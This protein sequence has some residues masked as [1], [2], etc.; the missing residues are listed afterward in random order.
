MAK[1]RRRQKNTKKRLNKRVVIALAVLG[2]VAAVAV[3]LS[4]QRVRDWLFPPDPAGLASE[5]GNFVKKAQ[6]FVAEADKLAAEADKLVAEAR[7]FTAQ[8]D[9]LTAQANKLTGEA[10][11]KYE[12]AHKAYR[13][14]DTKYQ[15]AIYH[16][17]DAPKKKAEYCYLRGKMLLEQHWVKGNAL[18]QTIR[19]ELLMKGLEGLAE[20]LRQDSKHVDSQRLMCETCWRLR[21]IVRYI[22]EAGKLLKLDKTDHLTWY[23]RGFFRAGQADIEGSKAGAA[24]AD[25][26]QAINLKPDEVDYSL[27]K[28]RFEREIGRLDDAAKTYKAALKVEANA[29]NSTLRV[30]YAWFLLKR[31]LRTEA[32]AQIDE[33]VKR[34]PPG[35]AV[36]LLALARFLVSEDRKPAE[37]LPVLERA[38]KVDPENYQVYR[39]LATTHT[40]LKNVPEAMKILR[41]GIAKIAEPDTTPTTSPAVLRRRI[42]SRNARAQL[43]Y[44]LAKMLIAA[45]QT[46]PEKLKRQPMF[47]EARACAKIVHDMGGSQPFCDS[48]N[49]QVAF[50][51]GKYGQARKLL[52]SAYKAFGNRFEPGT[53]WTLVELYKRTAALNQAEA[54]IDRF[55]ADPRRLNNA[56]LRLEKAKI[57]MR[58]G[59]WSNAEK[60]VRKAL[61]IDESSEI[62]KEL[63]AVIAFRSGRTEQLSPDVKLT[64]PVI[65]AV[66]RRS[67]AL[68]ADERRQQAMELVEDLFGRVPNNGQVAQQLINMYQSDKK[69]KKLKDLLA[70]LKAEQPELARQVQFYQGLLAEKDPKKKLAMQVE[71]VGKIKDDLQRELALADLYRSAGHKDK[72]VEHLDKAA[73][74]K[75]DSAGVILRRFRYAV[76]NENWELAEKMVAQGAKANIDNVNG[77]RLKARLAARRGRGDSAIQTY[78]EIL[79]A[80]GNNMLVRIERGQLYMRLGKLDDAAK[81]FQTVADSDPSNSAGAISMMLVTERQGKRE[82]FNKWLDRAHRLRPGHPDVLTRFT[83]RKARKATS[84]DETIATRRKQLLMAPDDLDN[85]LK[86]GRLYERTGKIAQA[87]EMFVSVLKRAA[88]K[89]IATRA[90]VMFYIRTDR[91]GKA[92]DR[93]QDLLRTTDNKIGGYV[94]YGEFLTPFKPDQ[95]RRA[96]DNAIKAEPKNP[97]GHHALAKFHA[98]RRMWDDAITAMTTCVQLSKNARAFEE[99][100]IRYQINGRR[101]AP[102][103][104]RL[105]RILKA[106]PTTPTA[107]RLM[108][109]LILERDSDIAKAEDLLST[110]IRENPNDVGSLVAR[111][112]LYVAIRNLDKARADYERARQISDTIATA[113][114]LADVC[115]GL[116]RYPQAESIL[117]GLLKQLPDRRPLI[118]EQLVGLY[119]VQGDKWPE[120]EALLASA[121]KAEPSNPRYQI[122]TSQMWRRRKQPD[123]A[124]SALAAAVKIAPKSPTAIMTYVDALLDAEQYAKVIEVTGPYMDKKD[125]TPTVPAMRARALVKSGKVDEGQAILRDLVKNSPANSLTFLAGQLVESFGP[126]NTIARL[127]EWR[128]RV[129][130][131]QYHRVLAGLHRQA[132]RTGKAVEILAKARDLAPPGSL[133]RGQI[134]S[135]LGMDYCQ[136]G[137]I[138]E[139]EKAYLA[140]LAVLPNS[141][142]LLNNLAF[143]YA[144]DLNNPAKA[145]PYAV[146]AYRWSSKNA[147]V[148]DTYAWVLAKLKR[149]NEA[150]N[151]LAALVQQDNAVPA[152]R[153]HLGWIYE[154]QGKR[155]EALKQYRYGQ[156]MIADKEQNKKLYGMFVAS[157]KRIQDKPSR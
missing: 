3:A 111:A 123:K 21:W 8:A 59:K 77:K 121:C 14:A 6:A 44:E 40:L 55:L 29:N 153:Y 94:L 118:V 154:Q 134:N 102:A 109:K 30:S 31:G 42:L 87:E 97:A 156:A 130:E 24:L 90:L 143:M 106:A 136:M 60:L 129:D 10:K 38:R 11:D 125:F 5:A 145:L 56:A 128:G 74:V 105:D 100:L 135:Q 9:K 138:P 22:D 28:A 58:Y 89:L 150:E 140:A 18:S 19:R 57:L 49:G 84:L 88:D 83:D 132:K 52:E 13:Q 151:I 33:A 37:A 120:L 144:D 50:Y 46:V 114:P 98:S 32:R 73:L 148:A 76:D 124:L 4:S 27:S 53:A 69:D 72:F 115:R 142:S 66:L 103:Q 85:R 149:Y 137:R 47:D 146:K 99:D 25:M 108:A 147:N 39:E 91:L 43:N 71:Q 127:A 104:A 78:T 7:K 75:P 126:D 45:A 15:I 139:G 122:L 95:A 157:I 12:Q 26:Q 36:P 2:L 133:A 1:R 113:L 110:A 82:E 116:K 152:A 20:S 67:G 117:T 155:D 68:W 17:D 141:P 35:D 63:L 16:S 119:T 70:K 54:I 93:I 65:N 96:F 112:Q 51:E 107:L 62:A 41:V 79:K 81:D 34:A 61:Q 48:I 101:F 23:R 80:D 92:D 86:L 64:A 131:W